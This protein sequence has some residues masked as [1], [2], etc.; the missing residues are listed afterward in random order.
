MTTLVVGATG[1]TGR[2]LVEQLLERGDTVK[3]IVRSAERLPEAIRHRRELTIVQAPV[4]TLSDAELAHLVKDCDAVASCLGHNVTFKGLFLPPRRLVTDTVRRLCR[5][6]IATRAN[7]TTRFVLMSSVAVRHP[8]QDPPF[9]LAHRSLIALLR[10]G[11]PPH[12]DNEQAAAYLRNEIGPDHPQ[13]QWAAVRPDG[14]HD[15]DEVSDYEVLPS[16]T[17]SPLFDAGS[18]SRINVAHFMAALIREEGVWETWRGQ[19]PTVYD[20]VKC[21]V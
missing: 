18:T 20:D 17:R 16:P 4:L 8:E 11:L 5:A 9:S 19:M 1:A 13:I 14:L 6:I 12:A 10:L 2:L 15:D 3:V 7:T 21:E